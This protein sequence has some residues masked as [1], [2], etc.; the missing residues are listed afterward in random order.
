[1]L[2]GPRAPCPKAQGVSA[3]P[4]TRR[5][6][7]VLP[8]ST[9]KEQ[10]AAS[11]PERRVGRR[12]A[13][14]HGPSSRGWRPRPPTPSGSTS[15]SPTSPVASRST[16]T[17]TRASGEPDIERGHMED[18]DLKVTLDYETAKAILVEG[19]GQA[20]MT[21]VH[22]REGPGRR[23]HVEAAGPAGHGPARRDRGAGRPDPGDHV[24]AVT[25]SLAISVSSSATVQRSFRSIVSVIVHGWNRRTVPPCTK[26]TLPVAGQFSVAR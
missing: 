3:P 1:M 10:H 7:A 16:P 2:S 15:S 23:R 19:N 24:V 14:D 5:Y 12:G 25:P 11:V 22:G 18:A 9:P 17:S 8:S 4:T 26:N 13:Q 20:A 21:G 6:P